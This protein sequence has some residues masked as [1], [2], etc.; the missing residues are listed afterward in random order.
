MQSKFRANLI[1][2]ALLGGLLHP[3]APAAGLGPTL[4][5]EISTLTVASVK[6][7]YKHPTKAS[8]EESKVRRKMAAKSRRINRK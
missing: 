4:P 6:S 1:L 5:G 3:E 2:S 7:K 8:H